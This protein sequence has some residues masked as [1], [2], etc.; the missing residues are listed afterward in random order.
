MVKTVKEIKYTLFGD[1]YYGVL[2]WGR[3]SLSNTLIMEGL[4]E[5]ITFK[6]SP[7]KHEHARNLG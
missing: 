3:N 7:E 5:K 1:N 4:T 2:G 6:Q